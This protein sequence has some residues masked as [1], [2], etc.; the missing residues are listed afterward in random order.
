MLLLYI[1]YGDCVGLNK[2]KYASDVLYHVCP[3]LASGWP[4]RG[5][6]EFVKE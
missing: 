6:Y 4:G 3:C 1:K 2:S 5:D